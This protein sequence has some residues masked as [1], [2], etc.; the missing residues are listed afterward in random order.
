MTS[1]KRLTALIV[2][3]YIL[4]AN[5]NAATLTVCP[6]VCGGFESI[7]EA[8]DAAGEG[9]VVVVEPG[10]YYENLIIGKPLELRGHGGE[11]VLLPAEPEP[12][13][14]VT[15]DDVRISGLLFPNALT[16]I[17]VEGADGLQVMNCTFI[18]GSFG[19]AV[20]R[21]RDAEVRGCSFSDVNYTAVLLEDTSGIEVSSNR[22]K[23]GAVALEMRSSIECRI[24]ENR[25]EDVPTG[26][27]LI[28]G[29]GN[30]FAV[31][32]FWGC[33][34]GLRSRDSGGNTIRSNIASE[35]THFLRLY[36]SSQCYVTGNEAEEGRIYSQ[37]VS[38]SGNVYS[39]E[40][41]NLTGA[42]YE[43]TLYRP[44]AHDGYEV[45]GAGVNLTIVPDPLTDRGWATLSASFRVEELDVQAPE[46]VGFYEATD[47]GFTLLSAGTQ[48]DDTIS[49]NTTIGE[50]GAVIVLLRALDIG[51]PVAHIKGEQSCEAN[52][53]VTF[54][55]EGSTDDR[56][57]V[58]YE[59]SFGDG[60]TGAG[61][62]VSHAYAEA[63]TYTVTLT[64]RDAVGH[65]SS[66]SMEINVEEPAVEETEPGPEEPDEAT[67]EKGRGFNT[68]YLVA[69]AA[70]IA[71]A[72][73]YWMRIRK[74][75]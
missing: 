17:R 58:S 9:D 24:L 43:F 42:E 5:A 27:Q 33:V 70:V 13:I 6:D 4:G 32:E 8:I 19:V 57:I 2:A 47:D 63:G 56:G 72:A 67:D 23:E 16:A 18:E 46:D 75:Q 35:T 44:E 64:V 34:F 50:E 3:L 53:S 31:N 69:G 74:P 36:Q 55:A 38:S 28:E 65:S 15:S 1:M 61:V 30:E 40:G 51:P 49:L 11:T 10:V 60:D 39:L 26:I 45:L 20:L 73:F 41:F 25:F 68:Y 29:G 12:T 48:V 71:V 37:D 21:S 54:D 62:K 59:W 7:Q 66:K 22:F 14:L 52:Q